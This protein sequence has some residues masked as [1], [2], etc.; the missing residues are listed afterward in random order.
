[1]PT[2]PPAPAESRT[3]RYPAFDA[4]FLRAPEGARRVHLTTLA[5]ACVPLAAGIVLFGWRAAVVAT[6][7]VASCTAIEYVCYRV[8]RTPALAD[9]SH[10][11]LTGVLLALTL[12]AFTPWYVALIA[13]AFAIVLGKAVFGGV[14]HFLWQPALIG[15][16]AVAVMFP[17][18]L[19]PA[20]W[21]VLAQ[22]RLL[23][24]DVTEARTPADYRGWRDRPAP[25]GSDAFRLQ[26]PGRTLALL[27]R[28]TGEPPFSGLG[29]PRLEMPTAEPPALRAP[30]PNR[31][32]PMRDMVFGTRPG[33]IGETCAIVLLLAGLVLV[34]REYVTLHLPVA[35]L[36]SAWFVAAVAPIQLAGPS[37]TVETVWWPLL[38]GRWGVGFAYANYQVFS[39]ATLLA[40]TFLATEMSTRPATAGGQVIFGAAAGALAMLLQLYVAVPVPAYVAVL[41]MNT[42]TP[43]IDGLWRPRVL[44][45]G[46]FRF[47][48]R[49]SKPLEQA[50]P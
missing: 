22:S 17:A 37:E 31:L 46:R 34:Y 26:P 24:G 12:P 29:L 8:L 39:G 41:A 30:P 7:C 13:S 18:L 48:R 33:A 38:Y 19:N 47:L 2:D 4:P 28:P 5:V 9:R 50:D 6:I 1:M 3:R 40:A 21:T 15:R 14:G 20:D 27:T 43:W 35:F 25:E 42:F 49:R 16:F 10:A 36:L 44:G 11:Y 32:P 45:R 23:V